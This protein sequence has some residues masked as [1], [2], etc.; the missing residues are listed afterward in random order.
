MNV[1]MNVRDKWRKPYGVGEGLDIDDN[2]EVGESVRKEDN[3][4][5]QDIN[6]AARSGKTFRSADIPNVVSHDKGKRL[7]WYVLSIP[8]TSGKRLHIFSHHG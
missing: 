3:A 2:E 5:L 1:F 7:V 4:N 8:M 6:N